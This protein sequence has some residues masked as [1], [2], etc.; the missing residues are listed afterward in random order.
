M[1][2]FIFVYN[3]SKPEFI[4]IEYSKYNTVI[5]INEIHPKRAFTDSFE[6]ISKFIVYWI[7]S[8]KRKNYRCILF[9]HHYLIKINIII[10]FLKV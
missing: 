5:G 9:I 8:E 1:N 10:I 2:R 4:T 3:G 7:H 6:N